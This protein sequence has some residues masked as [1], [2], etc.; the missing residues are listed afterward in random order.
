VYT[1]MLMS[2]TRALSLGR[3][4][5]TLMYLAHLSWCSPISRARL[6]PLLERLF[7]LLQSSSPFIP[8]PTGTSTQK[9]TIH[10]F[11]TGVDLRS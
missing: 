9:R 3:R 7:E 11:A 5:D 8:P 6:F 1:L 2:V 10:E 4:A